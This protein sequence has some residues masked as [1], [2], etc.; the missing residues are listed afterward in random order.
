M[1]HGY[2][3]VPCLPGGGGLHEWLGGTDPRIRTTRVDNEIVYDLPRQP[4]CDKRIEQRELTEGR[5][6][7]NADL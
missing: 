3:S 2:Q 4:S 1:E 5:R 7:A 6:I